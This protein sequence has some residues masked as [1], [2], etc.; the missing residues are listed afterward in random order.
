MF[1]P[2]I[3]YTELYSSYGHFGIGIVGA[4]EIVQR[5]HL[6]AY[7]KAGFAV[8]GVTD[9]DQER[10]ES[11]AKRF[12]IHAYDDLDTM[13]SDD[14]IDVID[15]AIPPQHQRDIV[16]EVVKNGRHV[17]CQKP[18]AE[19]LSD[20]EAIASLVESAGVT[21]AVNQQFQWEKSIRATRELLKDGA[22]GTPLRGEFDFRL[23][24]DWTG[25]LRGAPRLSL[26]Y[27]DIHYLDALRHL[28]G[29]PDALYAVGGRT[30]SQAGVGETR[31]LTVLEFENDVYA[32]I[33]T[34]HN[35]WAEERA[36]YR[37]EGTEGVT[38]GTVGLFGDDSNET[39]FEYRSSNESEW[40]SYALENARFPDAFIGV[41][42]N[43]LECIKSDQTPRTT[44]R[45]NLETLKLVNAAYAS[46]A[47]KRVVDPG[48][49]SKD[50]FPPT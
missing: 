3:D 2:S 8:H 25:W 43:L 16:E 36:C 33:D 40:Q 23:D 39:T 7:Q 20:A 11:V 28:F 17:L 24:T 38:R 13:L 19:T 9:V 21:A 29:E 1:D 35:S 30:P 32:S 6:P 14:E 48:T 18:L 47:E 5:A 22:L 44:P 50:Y 26:L 42:G 37:F 10:A 46:M 31:V 41:M 45:D 34:N 4:G 49:I 27:F 12:G 15:V